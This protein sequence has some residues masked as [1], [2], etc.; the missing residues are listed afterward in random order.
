MSSRFSARM[1]Y[2]STASL[3]LSSCTLVFN[4]GRCQADI[5]R[6]DTGEVIPGTEEIEPGPRLEMS[7]WNEESQNLRFADFS[8]GVDLTRSN[9][10]GSWLD[11]ALLREPSWSTRICRVQR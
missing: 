5:L 1:L 9:F 7:G 4:V 10:G 8:G 11:D 2:L 6:W 3:S